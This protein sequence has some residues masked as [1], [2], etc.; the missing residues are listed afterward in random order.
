MVI[1]GQI[2]DL[3]KPRTH[4]STGNQGLKSGHSLS[5]QAKAVLHARQS[6][7]GD[8]AGAGVYW[9]STAAAAGSTAPSKPLPLCLTFETRRQ[10][11]IHPAPP[12]ADGTQ[13]M[14]KMKR[15][16]GIARRAA[17]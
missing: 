10:H 15:G 3:D 6:S 1:S 7:A 12:T 11:G 8:A 2:S 4:E 14:R 5:G 13:H 9:V 16:R 17:L